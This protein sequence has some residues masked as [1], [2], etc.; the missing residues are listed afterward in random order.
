VGALLV[1]ASSDGYFADAQPIV[2]RDQGASTYTFRLRTEK[3]VG[4]IAGRVFDNDTKRPLVAKVSIADTK[5]EPVMSSANT[6]F[7]RFDSLP[8]G[9]YNVVVER[10]SYVSGELVTEVEEAKATKVEFGLSRPQ[11]T[12][13][14]ETLVVKQI[15]T[16][17]RT[18]LT[19]PPPN[20]QPGTIISLKGVVFDFDKSD[21]RDDGRPALLE[22]AKILKQNPDVKVEVR[23]YTDSV[24]SDDYNIGLSERRAQAVFDF[25]VG[26]GIDANRMLVRGY[27][28][29]NPVASN[30]TDEGRQQ[31][32]RVDF[33]VAK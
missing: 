27:G 22:A 8:I 29:S 24:G 26:Q 11:V 14:V 32:R 25:L 21:I 12:A 9:L 19:R 5:L 6:G 3:P 4:T 17:G 1:Q 10:D 13:K 28:K 20:A 7:F 15:D 31:N 2:I 23:G 33:V 18:G 30:A 16:T